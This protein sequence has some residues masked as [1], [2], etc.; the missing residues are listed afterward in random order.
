MNEEER[1]A[2]DAAWDLPQDNGYI[3]DDEPM[4]INHVLDGTIQLDVS[5]AG[6]EF[7]QIMEEELRKQSRYVYHVVIVCHLH[8]HLPRNSGR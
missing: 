4:N 2:Y 3:T 5:Y 1:I 6:G 7:Q 8:A